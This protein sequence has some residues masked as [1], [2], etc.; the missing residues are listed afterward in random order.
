MTHFFTQ[1]SLTSISFGVPEY[2]IKQTDNSVLISNPW[3][4]NTTVQYQSTIHD[5]NSFSE[6]IQQLKDH[7]TYMD[8][9]RYMFNRKY[10]NGML[11]PL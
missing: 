9:T 10:S 8:L 3:N 7:P 4:G 1:W 5:E 11:A 6:I 2:I